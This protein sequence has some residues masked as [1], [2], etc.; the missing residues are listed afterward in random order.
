MAP[1]IHNK[2]ANGLQVKLGDVVRMPPAP[3]ERVSRVTSR[4]FPPRFVDFSTM[5]ADSIKHV[6]DELIEYSQVEPITLR[7]KVGVAFAEEC[8]LRSKGNP[9]GTAYSPK[10]PAYVRD[11]VADKWTPNPK[12]LTYC[13]DG[14]FVEGHTRTHALIRADRVRPGAAIE[15]HLHFGLPPGA[16]KN[17]GSDGAW[18]PGRVLN[19]APIVKSS[20]VSAVEYVNEFKIRSYTV[21]ELDVLYQML[22][23]TIDA[24]GG[25]SRRSAPS[26]VWGVLIALHRSFPIQSRA[27]A[28]QLRAP[29][30]DASITGPVAQLRE[31]ILKTRDAGAAGGGQAKF[32][33]LK[34]MTAMRAHIE[35]RAVSRL[36]VKKNTGSDEGL[37]AWF[38]G[39]ADTRLRQKGEG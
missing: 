24:V 17:L 30:G 27:F 38:K 28:D 2:K 5:A 10:M 15:I 3:P 18:D 22:R 26:P 1:T 21:D 37:Y 36:L 4:E 32:R 19:I 29:A 31:L 11:I 35:G 34:T 14:T 8:L 13:V 25:V 33:A 20:M 12:P 23:P 9:R 6:L 7:A 16:V 39:H